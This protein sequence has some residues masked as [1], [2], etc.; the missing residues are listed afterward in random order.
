MS[1]KSKVVAKARFRV[2]YKL[3]SVRGRVVYGAPWRDYFG[4]SLPYMVACEEAEHMRNSQY[5]DS[6]YSYRVLHEK[7]VGKENN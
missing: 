6:D 4:R 2:M 7:L 1:V 3:V 5:G